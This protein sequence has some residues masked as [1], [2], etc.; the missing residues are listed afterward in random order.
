MSPYDWVKIY[1]YC[2]DHWLWPQGFTNK[3][4]RQN[5][6]NFSSDLVEVKI[7]Q[8]CSAQAT[9]NSATP[10][11]LSR[12]Q[13]GSYKENRFLF[14]I[15]T[16]LFFSCTK[17]ENNSVTITYLFYFKFPTLYPPKSF[18]FFLPL[19]VSALYQEDCI[20]NII[21]AN[22]KQN[23]FIPGMLLKKICILF[24]LA[25]S[26]VIPLICYDFYNLQKYPKPHIFLENTVYTS[27]ISD[28]FGNSSY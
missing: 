16:S 23:L 17:A 24:W 10:W 21:P 26:G 3:L 12:L 1:R 18:L 8:V 7:F 4:K 22:P 13:G 15:N 27:V 5:R 6:H 25:E 11:R 28:C 19:H 14:C 2:I 20:S 9:V